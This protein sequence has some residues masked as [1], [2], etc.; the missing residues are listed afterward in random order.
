[1]DD[2]DRL[3]R[4]AR[5]GG[6][7]GG[8]QR[9]V[10]APAGGLAKGWDDG[11]DHGVARVVGER[12]GEGRAEVVRGR[13]GRQVAGRQRPQALG[14]AGVVREQAE[15]LGVAEDGDARSGGQ[16]LPGEQQSG[17]DQLGHRVHADHPG[18][19]QQVG[20]RGVREAGGGACVAGGRD[21]AV[22]GALDDDQG[23]HGGGAAG[24]AGELARVADG[25]EVHEGNVGVRVVVPVLEHVVAGDVR[26]VARA[27]A[28]GQAPQ[29]AAAAVQAGQERDADG[30]GLGEQ[31]E[32]S[33]ERQFGRERGVEAHLRRGVDDSEGVGSDDPHAVRACLA[34]EFALPLASLGAA[35]GVSGGDHDESLDAVFAAVGDGLR[36]ALGR[37]GDDGEVDRFADVAHG[38][39]GGHAVDLGGAFGER[40]VHRVQAAGVPRAEQV[41]QDAAADAVRGAARAD[42][43]DRAGREEALYGAG[44][45]ALFAGALDGQG[46]VGGFE[47]EF[48]AYDA[49]LE[50][51]LLLVARVREDLDHLG[52]G[53][54][55]LGGE[56]ADAAFAGD[57]RDVLEQRGGDA[58]ALVGVLDE[59]GDLGLVGGRGG[60]AALGVD[61]VVAHGGD[62]L[63]AHGGR[64]AHPV[65]VVVVGE[66]VH[67]LGGQARVRCEE[68][69]VL[70]LVRHLLEEADQAVGVLGCDGPDPGRAPVAQ[71]HVGLPVGGVG[72]PVRRRLHGARVRVARPPGPGQ[73]RRGRAAL[74]CGTSVRGLPGDRPAG[75]PGSA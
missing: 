38:A 35:L 26:A 53:G 62:E 59:E 27:D 68:A 36:D 51:A 14:D 15:G 16:G 2:G 7:E 44:L 57:G 17:V 39:M 19:A 12:G 25:F 49:V 54:Q 48:E 67:V 30:A 63:A 6:A 60:G 43:G 72:V 31:A 56:T 29:T 37:D 65:H 75:A 41:A 73:C 64:E 20:H 55:D 50:A 21:A 70:R 13:G 42:D 5:G 11:D 24:E 52:V 46:A 4:A 47:V 58:A 33:G 23:L 71:H 3:G 1:M 40:A 10:L 34:D 22:P 69:V 61:A 9:L 28:G 66:A 32:A 8:G 45:G 18:L 74:G